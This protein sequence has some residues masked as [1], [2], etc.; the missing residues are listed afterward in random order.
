MRLNEPFSSFLR[1]VYD[2]VRKLYHQNI[3]NDDA[4]ENVGKEVQGSSGS[5]RVYLY[6]YNFDS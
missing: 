5:P 4:V 6:I 2:L 3:N 1:G